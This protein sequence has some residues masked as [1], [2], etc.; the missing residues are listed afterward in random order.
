MKRPMHLQKPI[1]KWQMD[2]DRD[3]QLGSGCSLPEAKMEISGACMSN[4]RTVTELL[5]ARTVWMKDGG[6]RILRSRSQ[7]PETPLPSRHTPLS[8]TTDSL[9]ERIGAHE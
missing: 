5:H 7:D 9:L 6:K 1:A 4:F 8:H 3:A 2:I